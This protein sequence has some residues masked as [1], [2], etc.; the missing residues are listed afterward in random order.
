VAEWKSVNAR[1][2]TA[3]NSELNKILKNRK[4]AGEYRSGDVII[5][6]AIPAIVTPE[7]FDRAQVRL[8]KNKRGTGYY[9]NEPDRFCEEQLDGYKPPGCFFV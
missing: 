6:D 3:I 4:Y 1:D 9:D 7:L 8:E 5:P 2:T